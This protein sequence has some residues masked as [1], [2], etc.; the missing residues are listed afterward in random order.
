MPAAP[1]TA[2]PRRPRRCSNRFY[3]FRVLHPGSPV[4]ASVMPE[5]P[6]NDLIAAWQEA[7]YLRSQEPDATFIAGDLCST[8]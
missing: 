6:F 4:L 2:E 1:G 8:Q 7:G 5:G 3:V